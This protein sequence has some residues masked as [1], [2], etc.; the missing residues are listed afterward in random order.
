M[1]DKDKAEN[2]GPVDSTSV[3]LI[4]SFISGAM[5]S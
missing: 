2:L 4:S 1:L 3:F 5:F